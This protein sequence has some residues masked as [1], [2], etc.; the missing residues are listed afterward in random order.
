VARRSWIIGQFAALIRKGTIPRSDEWVQV[1]LEWFIVHGT[2]TIKKKSQKSSISAVRILPPFPITVWLSQLGT[3]IH[4]VPSPPYSDHVRGQCR[5]RLLGCLADLTQLS[6]VT[7]TT[8]KVQRSTGITW[9][10]QLWLSR[11]VEIIRKLEQ[12]SKHVAL[13]SEIDEDDQGK[14]EHAHRTVAWLREVRPKFVLLIFSS[15][16]FEC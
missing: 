13:L 16:I 5:E 11:V 1:I 3:Q 9:D 4:S 10:G 7:K 6:I 12:D 15:E 8:E 2:F 14:L